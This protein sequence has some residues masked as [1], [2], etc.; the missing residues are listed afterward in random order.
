MICGKG[1]R[2]WSTS[3]SCITV[4]PPP[5]YR[6]VVPGTRSTRTGA[7]LAGGAPSSTCGT[8]GTAAPTA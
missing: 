6:N 8:V 5:L 3:A 2:K 7:V 4:V 1:L